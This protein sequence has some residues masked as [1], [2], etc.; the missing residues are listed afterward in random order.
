MGLLLDSL[1]R[2]KLRLLLVQLTELHDGA[3]DADLVGNGP[4]ESPSVLNPFCIKTIQHL[5]LRQNDQV[6]EEPENK[7][8][9]SW[10][11]GQD[12]LVD[13]HRVS[14]AQKRI[15]LF[16]F[17]QTLEKSEKFSG[18]GHV[19]YSVKENESKICM[20][21]NLHQRALKLS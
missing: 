5:Y 17:Q 8:R 11:K 16:V 19:H 12:K 1:G 21:K 14:L 18:I 10:D 20:I 3:Y 2:S 4:A 15:Y 9:Y 6:V 7:E 13:R